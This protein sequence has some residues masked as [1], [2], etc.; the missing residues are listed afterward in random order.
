M[1]PFEGLNEIFSGEEFFLLI[2]NEQTF[3]ILQGLNSYSLELQFCQT[4][5]LFFFLI[6]FHFFWDKTG[7]TNYFSK[8]L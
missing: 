5:I 8:I 4:Q 2:S 6:N 3:K 7:N 1:S